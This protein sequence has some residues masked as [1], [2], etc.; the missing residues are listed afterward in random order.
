MHFMKLSAKRLYRQGLTILL[1]IIAVI[2]VLWIFSASLQRNIDRSGLKEIANG[3]DENFNP[4]D[5]ETLQNLI[6]TFD[7]VTNTVPI[8]AK[9]IKISKFRNQKVLEIIDEN[10]TAE[11]ISFPSHVVYPEKQDTAFFYLFRNSKLKNNKALLWIPGK[12]VSNFAFR[13][14]KNFFHEELKHGYNILIYIP[15]YHIERKVENNPATFFRSNVYHNLLLY[16]ECV[17]ELRTGI[18]FLK[19]NNVSGISAWGGSMGGSMLCKLSNIQS[20]DYVCIMIPV[21]DWKN[22]TYDNE[23]IQKIIPKYKK[24]GFDK[25]LLLNAYNLISPVSYPLNVLPQDVQILYAKY[26]EL[27]PEKVTLSF[28][29]KHGVKNVIGYDRS[30]ATILLSRKLF[31]DYANFL[32]SLN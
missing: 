28:A 32:D 25:K 23:I 29:K 30:H 24:A 2:I 15:P 27:T 22:L 18:D 5:P 9:N 7:F 17:R 20:F 1:S 3:F 11:L 12:G 10:I 8:E 21:L 31:N 26:D 4:G 19:N 14:I 6:D 13:F 16:V